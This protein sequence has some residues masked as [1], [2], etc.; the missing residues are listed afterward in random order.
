MGRKKQQP[1]GEKVIEIKQ[2][3]FQRAIRVLTHDVRPAEEQNAT[4]R[5]DLSAAW[6]VIEDECRCNKGATKVYA[7]IAGMSDEKRDDYLRTLYGLMKT[8]GI[9]ISRDLVDQMSGDDAPEMPIV[10][11]TNG[12]GLGT[13]GAMARARGHLAGADGTAPHGAH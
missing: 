3:D 12:N 1:E 9:G 5:G 8:G 7:K 13:G 4:S 6:K 11:E 10:G 2:P